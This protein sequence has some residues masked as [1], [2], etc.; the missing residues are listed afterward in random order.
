MLCMLGF[1]NRCDI[2][3]CNAWYGV[4]TSCSWFSDATVPETATKQA[5]LKLSALQSSLGEASYTCGGGGEGLQ[6]CLLLL[7]LSF[8]DQNVQ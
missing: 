1:V 6:R 4:A 5:F 3:K 8:G 7:C 2:V